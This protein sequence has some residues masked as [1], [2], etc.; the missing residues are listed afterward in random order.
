MQR[1]HYFNLIPKM[2]TTKNG[3]LQ[4]VAAATLS[5]AL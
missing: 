4:F 3:L 5:R 1:G 2:S